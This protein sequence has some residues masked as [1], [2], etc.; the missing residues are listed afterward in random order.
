MVT[1]ERI[2]VSDLLSLTGDVTGCVALIAVVVAMV[3]APWLVEWEPAGREG[4][5][6]Q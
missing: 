3:I 4:R 6:G 1:I 5:L 2:V